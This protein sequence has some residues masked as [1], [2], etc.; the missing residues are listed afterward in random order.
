MDTSGESVM[1]FSKKPSTYVT[2]FFVYLANAASATYLS[3]HESSWIHQ[4]HSVKIGVLVPLFIGVCLLLFIIP[5]ELK[6]TSVPI[7]K[8]VLIL[9][10]TLFVICFALDLHALGFFWAIVP[11]GDPLFDVISWAAAVLVGVRTLQVLRNGCEEI[12]S[13]H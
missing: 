4:Q 7:E 10:E 11:F 12:G 9:T 5:A 3:L 6:R 1:R 13:E 2:L 8:V